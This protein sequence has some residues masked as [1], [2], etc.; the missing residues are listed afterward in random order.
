[1]QA[2]DGSSWRAAAH[3]ESGQQLSMLCHLTVLLPE[4]HLAVDLLHSAEHAIAYSLSAIVL[5]ADLVLFNQV[6]VGFNQVN[7]KLILGHE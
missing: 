1:M 4:L 3:P 2:S 6:L 7:E 5:V